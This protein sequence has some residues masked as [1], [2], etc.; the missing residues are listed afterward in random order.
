MEHTVLQLQ[1]AGKGAVL[2]FFPS[3]TAPFSQWAAFGVYLTVWWWCSHNADGGGYI[4]QRMMSAKNEKHALVGTSWFALAHYVLRVW[5]WIVVALTSIIILPQ[6]ITTS[7]H[8]FSSFPDWITRFLPQQWISDREAY[9]ALMSVILPAG[10]KGLFVATFLA[11]FMSTIVTHVNWGASYM[12]NDVYKRFIRRDASEKH[13][14]RLSKLLSLFNMVIGGVVA[15]F[16]ERITGAW[17]LLL[18]LGAGVGA[19]LILRWFWWRI[20]AWSEI[21]AMTASLVITTTI[22]LRDWIA[23]DTTPFYL[24][25]LIVVGGSVSVWL[26]VTFLT[27]PEPEEVLKKFYDRIQPGGWWPFAHTK[28]RLGRKI[29]VAWIGGVAFIYGSMFFLG[30]LILGSSDQFLWEIPLMGS[31]GILLWVGM[32]R[33]F[34]LTVQSTSA[35]QKSIPS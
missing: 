7:N 4:I 2:S 31:G 29:I 20:N 33:V 6:Y 22:Y 26:S 32:K 17:E 11:A 30:S 34:S 35:S 10:L 24:K 5:P 9:P 12:V 27:K 13:Y 1:A 28:S 23:G 8:F 21:S 16:I 14:L 25:A 15:L 19:V 3:Q 18:S